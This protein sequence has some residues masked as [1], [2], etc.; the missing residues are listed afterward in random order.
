MTSN[1]PYTRVLTST[2]GLLSVLSCAFG[3]E[4]NIGVFPPDHVTIDWPV[5]K[6]LIKSGSTGF[7]VSDTFLNEINPVLKGGPVTKQWW[8]MFP[9]AEKS[10]AFFTIARSPIIIEDFRNIVT[11]GDLGTNRMRGQMGALNSND[12]PLSTLS[13]D[14]EG[15]PKLVFD[16]NFAVSK[17][18]HAFTGLFFTLFGAID[19]K[20]SRDG[21]AV[22]KVKFDEYVLNLADIDAPLQEPGGPRRIVNLLGDVEW[23]GAETL[24]VIVEIKDVTGDDRSVRM[25]LPPNIGRAHL[26]WDFRDP[27]F[28]SNGPFDETRAKVVALVIKREQNIFSPNITNP[29]A[30]KFILHSLQLLPDRGDA[31]PADD[32]ALLDLVERRCVQYV[33]D[34]SGRKPGTEGL[35][36]DRANFGDLYTTG[37]LGFSLP[38]M[39]TA[40]ER[41]W[42]RREDIIP[43]ILKLLRKLADPALQGPNAIGMVGHKGWFYHFFGID[44]LRKRNAD[45]PATADDESRNFVELS[46]IDTALALFGILSV[47]SYFDGNTAEEVELRNLAQTIFDR[48]DWEFMIHR[49]EKQFFLAWQPE[50]VTNTFEIPDSSGNGFFS[51]RMQNGVITD[52]HTLDFLTDE[53]LCLVLLSACAPNRTEAL[54]SVIDG[55]V[56]HI[57]ASGLISSWPGSLFTYQ[58]LHAFV[59]T[60]GMRFPVRFGDGRF[61]P[62]AN[63]RLAMEVVRQFCIDNEGLVPTIGPL[64]WGITAAEDADDLYRAAGVPPAAAVADAMTNGT[65]A[66]YGMF[67]AVSYGPEWRTRAIDAMREAFR[68]GQWDTRFGPPDAFNDDISAIMAALPP[69]KVV[70]SS[71]PWVNW[72]SFIIDVGPV[73]LHI[74]NARSGLIWRLMANNPNIQRGRAFLQSMLPLPCATLTF[75][76]EDAAGPGSTMFRGAAMG[77]RTRWL[78]NGE[79]VTWN[80]NLQSPCSYR[81]RV[82]YSNDNFGPLE[83][84]NIL[85]DEVSIGSFSALDTGD[86]GHGWNAFLNESSP[87]IVNVPAGPHELKISVTGGDG[88]GVEI[89]E[90][91]LEL[92]E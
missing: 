40:A 63:A 87:Q 90:L 22:E 75:P 4:I 65:V 13:V 52:A 84:V 56:H 86:F 58:F 14:L 27:E 11:P 50:G 2:I 18:L 92:A 83:T 3:N 48:V 47:Q 24:E 7:P 16:W 26:V 20:T 43:P 59:N 66:W 80:F 49:A 21:V 45:D 81:W 82:R 25:I 89:D 35:P 61:D 39:I 78:H 79:S 1:N 8:T 36:Q 85:L 76:G 46:A 10:R 23:R 19:T 69:D 32:D 72:N 70:R 62:F 30:G 55:W 17:D 31:E 91:V 29:T 12:E 34:W 54:N 15:T 51:G 60:Q 57:E 38:M 73:A 53:L 37:G 9:T 64:T 28:S 6:F 77:L 67:S 71:G 44:G 5:D 68:R 88:F 74:E 41:G 42:A 33:F